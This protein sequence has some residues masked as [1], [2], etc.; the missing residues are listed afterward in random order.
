MIRKAQFNQ[1]FT[2]DGPKNLANDN[3]RNKLM[4]NNSNSFIFL[5]LIDFK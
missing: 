4:K 5:Y 3:W 1:D 2:I